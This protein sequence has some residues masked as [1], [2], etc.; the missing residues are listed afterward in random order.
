MVTRM[1][2]VQQAPSA[3]TASCVVPFRC[4]HCGETDPRRRDG[5]CLNVPGSTHVPETEP[6]LCSR[7]DAGPRAGR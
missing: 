7:G 6:V 2:E 4:L 1:D 3:E 5:R